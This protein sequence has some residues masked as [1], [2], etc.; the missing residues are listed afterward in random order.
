M[1]Q[2]LQ[3][4]YREIQVSIA[5]VPVRIRFNHT[6][7]NIPRMFKELIFVKRIS[8]PRI[9]IIIKKTEQR[10]IVLSN[11]NSKLTIGGDEVDNF[12][13]PFN[14]IGLLQ[15]TLRFTGLYAIQRDMALLHASTAMFDGRAICFGDDGSSTA[16]SASSLECALSSNQYIGD[17]FCYLNVQSRRIHG[18]PFVPVHVRP[19]V[20]RHL[21]TLHKRR[22]FSRSF[23]YTDAGDFFYPNSYFRVVKNVPLSAFVFVHFTE[24]RVSYRR[25][26]YLQSV[27]SV[28]ECLTAH[29]LKLF[30]PEYD[31]MQFVNRDDTH[32]RIGYSG[33]LISKIS[34]KYALRDISKVLVKTIPCFKFSIKK[35][36]DVPLLLEQINWR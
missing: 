15:A 36:C 17:E 18:Y 33:K 9:T 13:N 27:N 14:L 34:K 16:K 4:S 32:G 28:N 26:N 29:F 2:Q 21:R 19:E 5:S 31:N 6:L 8:K 20:N 11:D 1:R 7:N 23:K 25:L 30:N 3:N 24:Q 22:L 35:L 10:E 12:K